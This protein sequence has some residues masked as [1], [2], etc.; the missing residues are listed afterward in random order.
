MPAAPRTARGTG[1]EPAADAG[2][3]VQAAGP[4]GRLPKKWLSPG[5]LATTRPRARVS[6]ACEAV[7][8]GEHPAVVWAAAMPGPEQGAGGPA[9]PGR[10]C[11]QEPC[12]GSEGSSRRGRPLDQRADLRGFLIS[13][14]G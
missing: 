3:I 7:N 12:G 13:A 14:R 8:F 2:A 4:R 9:E 5:T 11:P 6:G 1:T 10:Y